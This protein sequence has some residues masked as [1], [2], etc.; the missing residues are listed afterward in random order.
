MNDMQSK[1]VWS[2]FTSH[3]IYSHCHSPR[4][5]IFTSFPGNDVVDVSTKSHPLTTRG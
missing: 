2:L 1:C 4:E 3:I 5:D